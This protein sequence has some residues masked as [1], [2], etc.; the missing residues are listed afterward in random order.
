MSTTKSCRKVTFSEFDL[1]GVNYFGIR[2]MVDYEIK[3]QERLKLP[4]MAP[5]SGPEP[6]ASDSDGN[7]SIHS[8]RLEL[9]F[10]IC[11]CLSTTLSSEYVKQ[12]EDPGQSIQDNLNFRKSM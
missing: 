1:P 3:T 11:V 12:L 4:W 2:H 5:C 9:P 10:S 7:L 8:K 6:Q